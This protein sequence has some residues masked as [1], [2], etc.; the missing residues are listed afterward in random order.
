VGEEA[1][2]VGGQQGASSLGQQGVISGGTRVARVASGALWRGRSVGALWRLAR[3][4]IARKR[5]LWWSLVD[6]GG[7][8]K[9]CR[10]I[11][12]CDGAH[13]VTLGASTLVRQR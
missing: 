11:S 6:L 2:L 8:K 5:A 9:R 1:G 10:R 13:P 7:G 12:K 4:C 3:V